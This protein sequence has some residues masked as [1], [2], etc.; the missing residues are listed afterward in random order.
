MTKP[1]FRSSIPVSATCNT[2]SLNLLKVSRLELFK[3]LLTRLEFC[4][5]ITAE[6]FHHV[7]FG[8]CF[9]S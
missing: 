6:N 3:H 9:F 2:N 1:V 5:E 7:V 4:S 8:F